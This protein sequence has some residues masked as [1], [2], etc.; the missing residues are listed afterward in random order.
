M[1]SLCQK[2]IMLLGSVALL[3]GC[4]CF[5][6]GQ[7]RG[8]VRVYRPGHYHNIRMLMNRRAAMRKVMRKH[9]QAARK[10]RHALHQNH[11]Q[12]S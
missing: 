6:Q 7:Y 9:R 12:Q 4:F 11:G 8:R 1:K 2:S 5:A 3:L 10:R